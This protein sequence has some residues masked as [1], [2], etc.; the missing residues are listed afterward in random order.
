MFRS[1]MRPKAVLTVSLTLAPL[2]ASAALDEEPPEAQ[3]RAVAALPN[4]RVLQVVA[5]PP[6]AILGLGGGSAPRKGISGSAKGLEQTLAD[7]QARIVGQEIRIDLAADVLFDLDQA[8]IRQ[9]ATTSLAKVAEVIR[10]YPASRVRV[11]GHTDSLGEEAYNLRLSQ[12]RA[13]AVVDWLVRQHG[14]PIEVFFVEAWGESRPV[15][16][17]TKPD[18]SDNPSGRQKNRRVEIVVRVP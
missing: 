12:R 1:P 11:A 8:V 5:F 13:Q 18:G 2:A 10:A 14:L 17:N 4:S 7:L 16:A 9:E 6:K 3:A 15:A